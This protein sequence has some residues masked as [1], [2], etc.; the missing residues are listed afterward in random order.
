MKNYQIES[1]HILSPKNIN[2][3]RS[4]ES[5]KMI[6]IYKKN[7][8]FSY[9]GYSYRMILMFLASKSLIYNLITHDEITKP[10]AEAHLRI[11]QKNGQ[12]DR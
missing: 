6:Y 2:Y 12:V 5:T 10:Q 8:F 7:I 4:Q 1:H 11:I 3:K 9:S